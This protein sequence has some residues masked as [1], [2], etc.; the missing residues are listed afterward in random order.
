MFT[1][2][3]FFEYKLAIMMM[4]SRVLS[5]ELAKWTSF[6]VQLLRSLLFLLLSCREFSFLYWIATYTYIYSCNYS[7]FTSSNEGKWDCLS[8]HMLWFIKYM[9]FSS[10]TG[11]YLLLSFPLMLITRANISNEAPQLFCFKQK[12]IALSRC[13]VEYTVSIVVVP[14]LAHHWVYLYFY[15]SNWNNPLRCI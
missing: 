7:Q 3:L 9:Y 11:N 15:R 2:A 12:N 5:H 10:S 4:M 13:L 14:P 6:L 1:C 8:S